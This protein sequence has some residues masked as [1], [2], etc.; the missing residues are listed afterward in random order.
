ME[1]G[2]FTLVH[3]EIIKKYLHYLGYFL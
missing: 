1:T 2:I 3:L